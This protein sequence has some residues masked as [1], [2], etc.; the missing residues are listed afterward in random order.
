LCGIR[1]LLSLLFM[2]LSVL[3][4]LLLN[5][6]FQDSVLTEVLISKLPLGEA[7][8][9]DV[10]LADLLDSVLQLSLKPLYLAL[11][12]VHVIGLRGTATAL[13]IGLGLARSVSATGTAVDRY[14]EGTHDIEGGTS[15]S[16]LGSAF[17][18]LD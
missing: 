18:G 11:E 14:L 17:G 8:Y 7:L 5:G 6:I 10:L 1:N 2:H 9:L 15:I 4:F 13:E 12:S 3:E 16:L